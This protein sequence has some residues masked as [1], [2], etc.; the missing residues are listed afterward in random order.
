[1]TLPPRVLQT[2]CDGFTF[3][4]RFDCVLQHRTDDTNCQS[5]YHSFQTNASSDQ[6]RVFHSED[7]LLSRNYRE[8]Y[9]SRLRL[10]HNH[11]QRS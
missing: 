8:T 3:V 9:Y 2:K 7:F 1:M 5:S 4:R 10:N 11:N 6:L